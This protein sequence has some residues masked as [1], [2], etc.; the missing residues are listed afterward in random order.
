[1]AYKGFVPLLQSLYSHSL[2]LMIQM[3]ICISIV[4][5]RS[6]VGI[7]T[8]YGLHGQVIESRWGARFSAPVQS[9]PGDHTASYTTSTGSIPGVKRPGRSGEH[10]LRF[11]SYVKERVEL[12][13]SHSG[14][15]RPVLG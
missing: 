8:H 11:R 12:Y 1:M 3:T 9:G 4:E 15:S 7:A 6:S 5:R 10:P 2:N 14:P 13:I